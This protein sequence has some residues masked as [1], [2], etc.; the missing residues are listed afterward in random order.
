MS[1]ELVHQRGRKPV[2]ALPTADE[3]ERYNA[4]ADVLIAS[5]M[6][7]AAIDTPAKALALMIMGREIG[8]G[9]FESCRSIYTI[10]GKPTLSAELMQSLTFT[11]VPGFEFALEQSTDTLCKIKGRRAAAHEW[12][13]ITFSKQDAERAGLLG[14]G[15]WKQYPQAMLRARAISALCRVLCPDAIRGTYTSEEMGRD[16]ASEVT[17]NP[18]NPVTVNGTEEESVNE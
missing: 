12:V 13:S 6:L 7:P 15:V 17:I 14:K 9:P 1:V 10:N 8:L 4:I 3:W 11:N 5:K 2:S 16:D 18:V